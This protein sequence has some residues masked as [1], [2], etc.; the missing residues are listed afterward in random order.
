M[1]AFLQGCQGLGLALAS[2]AVGGAIAGSNRLGGPA[3]YLPGGL[4]VVGGAILFG[5]SL[6]AEDHPA[7]PGW[8]AGA[9]VALGTFALT[10]AIVAA[11]AR[12]AGEHGSGASLVAI[13]IVFALALAA[14]SLLIP[15]V[16]LAALV[17]ALWLA[18]SRRRAASR[19]YEGLRVLR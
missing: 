4:A 12:R 8:V 17:V 15:P 2:G 3:L 7:W 5:A 18:L 1:D 13:V 9:I 6:A 14:L 19:K 16:S 11:A 10:A